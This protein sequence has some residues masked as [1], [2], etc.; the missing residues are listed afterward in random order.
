M[1]FISSLSFLGLGIQPPNADWG[2]MVRDNAM[3]INF[4]GLAPLIPASAIAFLTVGV[5]LVIDWFV[6]VYVRTHTEG[7]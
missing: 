3:A 2:S 6:S 1:L 4:G 7:T 5:N